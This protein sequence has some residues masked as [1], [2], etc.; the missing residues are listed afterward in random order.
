MQKFLGTYRPQDLISNFNVLPRPAQAPSGRVPNH[1]NISIRH[2]AISP[3]GDLVFFVQPDSHYV[4]TEGPIQVVEGQTPGHTLNPKSLVTLQ[5]IAKLIMKAFVEGMGGGNVNAATA[6]FSWATNDPNFA[7]RIMKVMTDM[8]VRQDL[9]NM[10]VADKDEVAAS[11]EA[12]G[13]LRQ[14][15]TSFMRP[16]A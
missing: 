5:T 14:Q 8:G 9:L 13:D 16:S 12:W 2:V 11:D 1:W 15:M 6:P 3:A 10:V 7:R 4:H